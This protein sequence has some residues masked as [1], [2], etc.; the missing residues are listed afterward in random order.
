[1]AL[2]VAYAG[3]DVLH[4]EPLSAPLTQNFHQCGCKLDK[5]WLGKQPIEIYCL[6]GCAPVCSALGHFSKSFGTQ[7]VNTF[8]QRFQLDSPLRK[9]ASER[10]ILEQ[11]VQQLA[12]LLVAVRGSW[13]PVGR[14][15]SPPWNTAAVK[16]CSR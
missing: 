4:L 1:M 7:H 8:G 13:L 3:K 15:L 11:A 5:P 14:G 16:F 10:I 12:P 2:P 9:V 6:W